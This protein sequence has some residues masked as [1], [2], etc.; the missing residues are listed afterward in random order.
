MD[1]TVAPKPPVTWIVS[2]TM[3]QAEIDAW[4]AFLYRLRDG[5]VETGVAVEHA[6]VLNNTFSP[7]Y[8]IV[9][10]AEPYA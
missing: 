7:F 5:V 2:L 4:K 10:Q 9:S 6:N 8:T 1:G 3:T